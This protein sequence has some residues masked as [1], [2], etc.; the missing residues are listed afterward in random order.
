MLTIAYFT[1]D[2]IRFPCPS[3]RVL[4][5]ARALGEDVRLLPACVVV[6]GGVREDPGALTAADV[7]LV[8]RGFPRKS[9]VQVLAAIVASG[10]P[11]IFEIDDALNILPAHHNK[12]I[13]KS[14]VGPAI[15]RFCRQA[16]LV[17]VST[18]MLASFY[19]RFAK[20]VTVV[21]N[22]LDPDLWNDS[23]PVP[24]EH[25]L[26]RIGFVGSANHGKDFATLVP[27]LREMLERFPNVEVVSYGGVTCEFAGDP[28]FSVIPPDY[29]Y[30]Q[31]PRRL[32]AVGIDIAVAPLVGSR[33]NRCKSNIKF[34]EFGFLGIPGVY[35]DLEPYRS[36]VVHGETG[37][38]CGED[39][40]SWRHA[41]T[42]LIEVP[43]LRHRIGGKARAVVRGSW[44]LD[45]HKEE[46]LRAYR[47]V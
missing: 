27:L 24:A 6:D 5:P 43:G 22:Y 17:T 3:I 47:M 42:S 29:L 28:R 35:A 30:E 31:H 15:E 12:P 16:S 20:R 9:T 41:L 45:Q 36:S 32:A 19:S 14:D 8:Q 1:L 25:D 34:L 18:P 13:Y 4:S 26:V 40:G 10:K 39:T 33:F 23:L 44:M 38:L 7:V 11:I 2:D 37:F 21:P 46:W